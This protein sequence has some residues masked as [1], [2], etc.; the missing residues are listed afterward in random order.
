M[1]ETC[2]RNVRKASQEVVV[3]SSL[4]MDM[5]Q[6]QIQEELCAKWIKHRLG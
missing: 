1:L 5:E 4:N 2:K 6:L 3:A